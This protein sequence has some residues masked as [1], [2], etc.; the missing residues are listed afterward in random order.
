MSDQADRVE[1]GY[2]P[3]RVSL[4]G[5]MRMVRVL[6]GV[7]GSLIVLLLA[8]HVAVTLGGPGDRNLGVWLLERAAN[9]LS[10]GTTGL[11]TASDPRVAI[12]IN[13]GVAILGWSLL[14]A[15]LVALTRAATLSGER[16]R[17][18][19]NGAGQVAKADW[20][21][22]GPRGA[23]HGVAV[24][25]RGPSVRSRVPRASRTLFTVVAI[26]SALETASLAT[27]Y[28]LYS[29]Y[30]VATD[31]ATVDGNK[32]EIN[33]PAAGT[34]TGW[35]INDGA[36]VRT[37]QIVGRIQ[38][39]SGGPRVV[40]MIKSPGSGWVANNAASNGS[41]VA[42]GTNL[43]TAYNLSA[44]YVT[45]RVKD[46]DIA[47]V[48]LGA[49]VDIHVDAFPH[50]PVTGVVT[51]VQNSAAGEFTIYPAPGTADPSNLQKVDQYIPVT[52]ALVNTGGVS[53]VPGMN[54]TVHIHKE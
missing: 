40:R 39:V 32:I 8:A 19:V 6:V 29:R 52:I 1:E 11:F 46:T 37:G 16:R 28:M 31:N 26:V 5:A 2:A 4:F 17:R 49:P 25:A 14:T 13:S 42:A 15:L 48:R 20:P 18:G 10:L 23:S 36:R 35:A 7:S 34:V 22:R 51:V 41:Y 27:T 43:A 38:S 3:P 21:G 33:A 45:A 50:T 24:S 44:I 12:L 54:V 47:G 9:A 53:L 30:Y